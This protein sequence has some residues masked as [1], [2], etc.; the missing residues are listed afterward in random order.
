[1][2]KSIGSILFLCW[3]AVCGRRWPWLLIGGGTT[4]HVFGRYTFNFVQWVGPA[5]WV[6][7]PT[8]E[9]QSNFS[10]TLKHQIVWCTQ[11]RCLWFDI[12]RQFGVEEALRLHFQKCS[13]HYRIGQRLMLKILLCHFSSSLKITVGWNQRDCVTLS[14]LLWHFLSHRLIDLRQLF[15]QLDYW[16]IFWRLL[17]SG[18]IQFVRFVCRSLDIQFIQFW[19]T[20][21]RFIFQNRTAVMLLIGLR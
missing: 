21:R 17:F 12:Q 3:N 7:T 16:I 20:N 15:E 1:M 2:A 9:N 11:T 5:L 18:V 13:I 10:F 8:P 19:Q 4:P 6:R 14:W